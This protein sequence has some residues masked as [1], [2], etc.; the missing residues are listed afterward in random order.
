MEMFH[1]WHKTQVSKRLNDLKNYNDNSF[2]IGI[3]NNLYEKIENEIEEKIHPLT[4]RFRDFPSQNIVE[5]TLDAQI[6]KVK[7]A[8]LF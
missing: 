5:K 3:D 6:A 8:R 4:F 2:I 1:K 7:T